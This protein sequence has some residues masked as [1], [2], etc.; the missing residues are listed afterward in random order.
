MTQIPAVVTILDLPLSTSVTG[1]E[2]FE[3]V[4]TAG[5][6]AV[7]VR[8]SLSQ[9]VGTVVGALPTG[10]GTGQVL[11]SLGAGFAAS[12]VNESALVTASTGLAAAGSTTVALSLASTAGLSVLGVAGVASAVPAAITGTADQVMIVGH[13]GNTAQF[14]AVNLATSAAV[15]GVL[16]GAN[17][18]AVNL[19]ASGA[20]GVQGVLPVPNGGTNTSTLTAFGAL[21][22][23]GTSTIGI[24]AAG[25]L[26]Q[27]LQAQ[28]TALAPVWASS[29]VIKIQN[30]TA[31]GTY[32]ASAGLLYALMVP[33]GGGGAGG[34]AVG[35][36][37]ASIGGGGGGSGGFSMAIVSA[38]G[39]GVFQTVTIGAG[40]VPVSGTT[41]GAGGS[42]SIG[43]ICMARGGSGGLGNNFTASF[44]NGGVGGAAG[45]GTVAAVG[46][47]GGGG[48]TNNSSSIFAPSGYGGVSWFGGGASAAVAGNPGA[49]PG[50]AGTVPGAGGSGGAV[51][52]T[53]SSVAGG[54]GS[55][56]QAFVIE[57]TAF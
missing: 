54:T 35:V 29:P 4:Q 11:Q 24:T 7:S 17:F 38:A 45:T 41:G 57:L 47:P 25:L 9:M 10:G 56:G 22:G 36:S 2:L 40:G 15:T 48:N 32:T 31:T 52:G 28:G 21:F 6:V 1:T 39:V 3:C 53:T 55:V 18:S 49:N 13:A 33:V 50:I 46:G 51:T 12:W 37:T 16:P 8:M 44:G 42:T 43:T 34:G 27:V 26:G 14:G 19:G 30:F 5:G 20:G 23:N